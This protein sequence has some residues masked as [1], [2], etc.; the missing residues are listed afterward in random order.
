MRTAR[1]AGSVSFFG[2]NAFA[3]R[4]ENDERFAKVVYIGARKRV[5]QCFKHG[6]ACLAVVAGNFHLDEPM[7]I[8]VGFDFFKHGIGKPAFPNKYNG[9]QGV[10][11]GAKCAALL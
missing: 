2:Q 9:T 10:G 3:I 6:D 5:A 4:P 11:S 1:V 7:G 8:Q